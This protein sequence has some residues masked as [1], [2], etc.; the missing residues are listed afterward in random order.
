MPDPSEL[1]AVARM[2]TAASVGAPPSQ[3][4]LGRAISTVYYALFHKVLRAGAQ[5][6]MGPGNETKPGYTL[7]YRSF[8]H[9]RMKAVCEALDVPTLSRTLQQQLG[10]QAVSPDMR[11]FAAAFVELQNARNLADYAPQAIFSHSDTI[12]LVGEAELALEA[13]DRAGPEEQADVL[14][15]MLVN[16]RT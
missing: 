6:F 12:G 1:L 8:A 10:R 7:I 4:Q 5:R 2:L 3:A 13:F 16:S 9:G 11:G 14:A 15:L